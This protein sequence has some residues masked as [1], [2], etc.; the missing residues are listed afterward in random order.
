MAL[1]VTTQTTVTLTRDAEA[2][3]VAANIG[4]KGLAVQHQGVGRV[5]ISVGGTAAVGDGFVLPPWKIVDLGDGV[6]KNGGGV[7]FYEGAVSAIFE[8]GED[9][10]RPEGVGTTKVRVIDLQ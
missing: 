3:L 8:G 7:D 6:A 10:S 4:R 5:W 2:T 1:T 9:S